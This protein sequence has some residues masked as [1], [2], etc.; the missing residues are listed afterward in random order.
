MPFIYNF[1]ANVNVA[2][3]LATH[4]ETAGSMARLASVT[5]AV[6][7]TSRVWYVEVSE[8]PRSLLLPAC[9]LVSLP[10]IFSL[11]LFQSAITKKTNK[12]QY[13]MRPEGDIQLGLL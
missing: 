12:K 5:I 1:Q 6:V 3:V 11:P 8:T 10:F 4:Q 7:R 9:L 2:N 13:H